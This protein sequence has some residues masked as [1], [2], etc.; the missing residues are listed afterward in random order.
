MEG[1][2]HVEVSSPS[3]GIQEE[4]GRCVVMMQ[5]VESPEDL[6]A[7]QTYSIL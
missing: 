1:L 2:L 3:G 6:L 4:P 5:Q 7:L